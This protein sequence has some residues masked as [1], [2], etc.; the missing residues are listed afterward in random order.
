ML[1][2]FENCLLAQEKQAR[3]DDDEEANQSQKRNRDKAEQVDPDGGAG[4]A[5]FANSAMRKNRGFL[6]Q[7][8][9]GGYA[10]AQDGEDKGVQKNA[11]I[12]A[13]ISHQQDDGQRIHEDALIPT[14]GAGN[15]MQNL[16]QV[17]TT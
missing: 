10:N 3:K 5:G 9:I 15:K 4:N 11:F 14:E 16:A 13:Q 8:M 6:Q 2:F 1:A 17:E 12:L 7:I